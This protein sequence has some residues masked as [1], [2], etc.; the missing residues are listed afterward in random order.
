M[1]CS[2][3]S[4]DYVDS[5]SRFLAATTTIKPMA[6]TFTQVGAVLFVVGVAVSTIGYAAMRGWCRLPFFANRSFYSGMMR[7]MFP[8]TFGQTDENF[9]VAERGYQI[10]TLMIGLM[11]LLVAVM[12]LV[13][14]LFIDKKP[15]PASLPE[16]SKIN[17]S[18]SS[19]AMQPSV[20]ETP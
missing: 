14:S 10:L 15:Q 16:A 19:Q 8:T 2:V 6:T 4:K 13:C 20:I 1:V 3:S 11:I 12:L 18:V 7:R 5:L 9:Q 17:A